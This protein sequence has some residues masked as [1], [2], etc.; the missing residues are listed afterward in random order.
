M[1]EDNTSVIK[2]CWVMG[3]T[4]SPPVSQSAKYFK[5][6][7]PGRKKTKTNGWVTSL[8]HRGCS[9]G[10]QRRIT[11]LT[12]V[13]INCWHKET[14]HFISL[15]CKSCYTLTYFWRDTNPGSEFPKAGKEIFMT[16]SNDLASMLDGE[17]TAATFSNPASFWSAKHYI[18]P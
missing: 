5:I 1:F 2:L 12:F 11:I 14:K 10:N 16:F 15:V 8:L 9:Q 18:L 3:L 17:K 7:G 13:C 4:P 6:T